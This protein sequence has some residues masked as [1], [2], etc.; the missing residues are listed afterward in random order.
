MLQNIVSTV[1]IKGNMITVVT[2]IGWP[3]WI[4]WCKYFRS[5]EHAKYQNMYKFTWLVDL[6]FVDT[7]AKIGFWKSDALV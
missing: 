5:V 6:I 4:K 1:Y 7:E 3:Q 2:N